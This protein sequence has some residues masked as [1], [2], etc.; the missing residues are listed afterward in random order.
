MNNNPSGFIIYEPATYR[1]VSYVNFAHKMYMRPKYTNTI[2]FLDFMNESIVYR[3][4]MNVKL[5]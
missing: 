5:S 3:L 2:G 4:D 1:W